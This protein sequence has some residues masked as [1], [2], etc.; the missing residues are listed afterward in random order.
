M[1]VARFFSFNG[2]DSVA[3]LKNYFGTTDFR[4]TPGQTSPSS[5]PCDPGKGGANCSC[6]PQAN[7]ACNGD[8]RGLCCSNYD[9]VNRIID[10][11]LGNLTWNQIF[12]NTGNFG[13]LT[14]IVNDTDLKMQATEIFEFLPM[15]VTNVNAQ[16]VE[17]TDTYEIFDATTIFETNYTFFS[18]VYT[19]KVDPVGVGS[20][21][22]N[23]YNATSKTFVPVMN[24][25]VVDI[26]SGRFANT[27]MSFNFKMASTEAGETFDGID[28]NIIAIQESV[29]G[30]V[31]LGVI[32]NIDLTGLAIPFGSINY[33]T[34]KFGLTGTIVDTITKAIAATSTFDT[35]D[36]VDAF[37][38]A[39]FVARA[40]TFNAEGFPKLYIGFQLNAA[41][42]AT[43]QGWIQITAESTDSTKPCATC[44][45]AFGTTCGGSGTSG[46]A[47]K[48]CKMCS[49]NGVTDVST[50]VYS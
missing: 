21:N 50:Y 23:D 39:D 14:N 9:N 41:T 43:G 32:K 37:D 1:A 12:T 7:N 8:V 40:E 31:N 36:F 49:G 6:D 45:S 11:G 10:S 42:S 44:D 2:L 38:Y 47:C 16:I 24:Y 3:I 48:P 29:G 20:V 27:E 25:D 22:I 33:Y 18:N 17:V 19:T 13:L 28:V 34:Y 35:T 15:G 4:L 30:F 5:G 26:A 46:N